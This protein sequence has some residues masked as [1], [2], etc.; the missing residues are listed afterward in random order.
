M[1]RMLRQGRWQDV[2]AGILV[3][4]VAGLLP[5]GAVYVDRVVQ[6]RGTRVVQLEA[7]IPENGGWTPSEVRVRQG[8]RV[9]LRVRSADV[10]HG[11]AIAGVN[12]VIPELYPGKMHVVEFVPDKPGVYPFFC[13]VTC[14]PQHE[15]MR[16]QLIVGPR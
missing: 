4:G 8:E 7:R 11:M 2:L 9:Q 3:I 10:V 15:R 1:T 5:A 12:V 16:G 14:S 6:A 13:I